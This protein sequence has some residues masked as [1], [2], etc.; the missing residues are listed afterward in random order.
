M[1][2]DLTAVVNKSYRIPTIRGTARAVPARMDL[3]IWLP[4]MFLLGLAVLGLMFAFAAACAK[5]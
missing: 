2:N 5:V 3:T 4:A 1:P